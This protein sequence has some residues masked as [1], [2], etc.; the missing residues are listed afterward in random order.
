MVRPNRLVTRQ[1]P[2]LLSSAV[3]SCA[4]LLLK[5]FCNQPC[6]ATTH[7]QVDTCPAC[8]ITPDQT[9]YSCAYR[10]GDVMAHAYYGTRYLGTDGRWN[11]ANS[12]IGLRGSIE[13]GPRGDPGT[14]AWPNGGGRRVYSPD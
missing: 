11:G 7:K 12:L 6:V 10:L 9:Y 13:I 2:R 1:R 8:C 3:C 4:I 5:L 14:K